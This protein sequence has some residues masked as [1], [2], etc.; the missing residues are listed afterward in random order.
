MTSLHFLSLQDLGISSSGCS[1]SPGLQCSSLQG[2]CQNLCSL[3]LLFNS[4]SLL[5]FSS[6]IQYANESAD[7]SVVSVECQAYL[8]EFPSFKDLHPSSHGCLGG[9]SMFSD[10]FSFDFNL[11]LLVVLMG[12][13]PCYQLA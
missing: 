12:G 7:D 3:V 5:S 13:F 11:A 4:H 6:S 1:G 10:N 2:V 9:F 8:S